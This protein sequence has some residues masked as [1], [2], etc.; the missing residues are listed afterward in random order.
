MRPKK[1]NFHA[2]KN[3]LALICHNLALRKSMFGDLDL[4][5][6]EKLQ[7]GALTQMST[8]LGEVLRFL[9]LVWKHFKVAECIDVG[10][11]TDSDKFIAAVTNK[12]M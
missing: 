12:T 11:F 10:P 9:F 2:E 7:F 8:K 3:I 5:L 1:C 4:A 6:Q